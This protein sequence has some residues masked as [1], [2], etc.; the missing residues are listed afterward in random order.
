MHHRYAAM[1]LVA[2][3]SLSACAKPPAEA[4]ALADEARQ[5]ALSAGAEE[6]A[7]EALNAVSE[8]KAA[9]DAEIAAQGE[10]MSLTRSYKHAEELA[11]EYQTAAD[12]ATAAATTA[13]ENARTEATNLI[14]EGRTALEEVRTLLASAPRGKGSRADLAAMGADLDAAAASLTEAEGALTSQMYLDARSKASA[15]RIVI[16]QVRSSIEQAQAARS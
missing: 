8:A 1:A 6:Y 15:A 14:A 16:D 11:M 10:K 5:G 12:Q 13:K 4:I 7:P 2:A 9:L 3:A